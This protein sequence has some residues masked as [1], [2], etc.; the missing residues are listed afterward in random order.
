ML[1]LKVTIVSRDY[2][3][4]YI[5]VEILFIN[6]LRKVHT[7]VPIGCV[8]D[9]ECFPVRAAYNTHLGDFLPNC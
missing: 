7:Q 5:T 8:L 3:S 6:E 1:K 9:L 4:N 2:I